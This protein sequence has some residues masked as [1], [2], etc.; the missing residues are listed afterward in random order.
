MYKAQQCPV[1]AAR[2]EQELAF[3]SPARAQHR[4]LLCILYLSEL[5]QQPQLRCQALHSGSR[6]CAPVS[7]AVLLTFEL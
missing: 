1:Q 3:V 2:S 7:L 5:Q 6:A 4:I